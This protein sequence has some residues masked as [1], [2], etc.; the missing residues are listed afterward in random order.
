MKKLYY[1]LPFGIMAIAFLV[2]EYTENYI[3]D[4]ASLLLFFEGLA[5]Y[6]VWGFSKLY[7]PDV[8]FDSD[9][10]KHNTVVA[11]IIV[12]VHLFIAFIIL[13]IYFAV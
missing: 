11:G 7:N 2:Y 12:G 3:I 4:M 1:L 6:T 10:S 13:G 9:D 5:Y 8:N